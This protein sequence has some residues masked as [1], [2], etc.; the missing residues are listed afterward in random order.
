M[1]VKLTVTKTV[2]YLHVVPLLTKA[3]LVLE[4]NINGSR[5]VNVE[6]KSGAGTC[7]S[8]AVCRTLWYEVHALALTKCPPAMGRIVGFDV[9]SRTS[10]VLL[11][12]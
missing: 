2:V 11:E 4:Q 7:P 9:R 12:K 1:P 5:G 3:K 6:K 10:P 8:G